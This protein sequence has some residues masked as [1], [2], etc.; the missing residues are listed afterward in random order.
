MFLMAIY[1]KTKQKEKKIEY[2][3]LINSDCSFKWADS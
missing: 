3:L 1:C 2:F